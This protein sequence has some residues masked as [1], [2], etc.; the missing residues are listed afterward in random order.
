MDLSWEPVVGA[1]GYNVY[2]RE[3]GE[4]FFSHS[5]EQGPLTETHYTDLGVENE[6][7]YIIQSEP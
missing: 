5:V 2:R 7:K 4:D 1:S 3:E 6:K